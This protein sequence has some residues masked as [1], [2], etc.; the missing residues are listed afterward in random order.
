MAILGVLVVFM[1]VREKKPPLG[2]MLLGI[3][4]SL[5]GLFFGIAGSVL[6]F[7][8]FFT[9]HDYTWHN[10]NILFIN[11][12]ILAIIPLGIMSFREQD[13]KK[14]Y[15]REIILKSLWTYIAIGSILSLLIRVFPQFYQQNQVTVALTLPFALGRSFAPDWIAH[16]IRIMRGKKM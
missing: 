14:R 15:R 2:R 12:L 4:Q 9:D 1:L 16:G 13:Q 6:F 7:M 5:L 10:S 8:T 3:S 11:P